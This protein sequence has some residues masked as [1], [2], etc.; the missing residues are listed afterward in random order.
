MSS[1]VQ[2]SVSVSS[3][4]AGEPVPAYVSRPSSPTSSP[5]MI[6]IHE[7]WGLTPH[8]KDIANRFAT[9]GYYAIAPDLYRGR[10]ASTPEEAGKLAASVGTETSKSI[11]DSIVHHL[12]TQKTVD[13]RKI[14]IIGYCFGGTHAFNYVCESERI[15]AGVLFYATKPVTEESKLAKIQAPLLIIYG[16]QDQRVNPETARQIEATLRKL[17]KNVELKLYPGCG[18]AF[19]NDQNLHGYKPDAAKDAW[20]KTLSFLQKYL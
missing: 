8:I 19:F 6:V 1:V 7:W 20:E 17:G 4:Q 2:E 9:R 3:L 14:G 18:H 16:D 13:A 11:L 10:L 5:A 15:S 12:G